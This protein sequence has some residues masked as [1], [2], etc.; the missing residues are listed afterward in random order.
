MVSLFQLFEFSY[1]DGSL[2]YDRSGMLAR[3]M[4][5]ALPGLAMKNS[6]LDQRDFV[7]PA[8][9]L[10][11]F[12]G[13]AFSRI[14]SASPGDQGFAHRAARFLQMVAEVFELH[15][16]NEFHFRLVL[17]R[18]CASDDE[19]N[20]LM[21]PLVPEETQAK[22]QSLT[23]PRHW[24]A[25]QGE[26]IE[27]NL[28]CQSRI[29]IIDMVPH[30]KMAGQQALPAVAVP[31]LTFHFDYRGLAPV[32]LAAFDAAAFIQHVSDDLTQGIISKLAPH[33]R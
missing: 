4:Q 10:E 1:P 16:L 7:L 2:F 33:L 31:H 6:T 5:D 8:E 17:G 11:L 26:F 21:W 32:K 23:S 13:I 29:A 24:R 30:P 28:G 15:H 3:R 22:L 18:T 12:Y 9:D 14:Q 25:L 20:R 19:A 27:G